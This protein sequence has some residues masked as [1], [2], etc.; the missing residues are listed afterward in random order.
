MADLERE[1]AV[2]DM[3]LFIFSMNIN[4]YSSVHEGVMHV[5]QVTSQRV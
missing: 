5:V 4:F 1:P 2:T 3:L